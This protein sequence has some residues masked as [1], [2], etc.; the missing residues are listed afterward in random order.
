M[1]RTADTPILILP[2]L[3]GSGPIPPM[4][5]PFRSLVVASTNDPRVELGRAEFFAKSWGSH[6]VAMPQAGH[7]NAASG[8]G[9]W[10]EGQALLQELLSSER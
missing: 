5:F 6:F 3:G 2:G 8:L 1:E 9:E 4:R 10:P 7:I